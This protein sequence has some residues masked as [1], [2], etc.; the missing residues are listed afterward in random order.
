MASKFAKFTD[1]HVGDIVTLDGGFTCA[2]SGNVT[3]HAHNGALF[4]DCRAG[5]HYIA[6]QIDD[7]GYCIGITVK[8]PEG[9]LYT[10]GGK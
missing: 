7:D 5:R 3:L 6:G 1:L 10:S 9:V 4:F 2:P 8:S